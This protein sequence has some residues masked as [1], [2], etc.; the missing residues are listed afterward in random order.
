AQVPTLAQPPAA[1]LL[2][3]VQQLAQAPATVVREETAQAVQAVA[4]DQPAEVREALAV[5]LSQVPAMIRRSLRRPSDPTGTTIP[6]VLR[7]GNPEDLL[8]PFLPVQ[9]PR[10][11]PGDRPP[12]V[13]DWQLEEL[14][15]AGGFGEVWRARN[16]HLT[17]A[18]PVAL[19]F[20]LDPAAKDRLLRHEAAV[21]N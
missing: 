14:L 7:L 12:G 5:Y 1:L 15:G 20:C 16:P 10:F 19:K 6:P 8:L 11:R 18:P 21:L 3:E 2:T 4:A 9:P 13:G 17:S